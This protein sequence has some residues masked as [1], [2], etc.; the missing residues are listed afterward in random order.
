MTY[1]LEDESKGYRL[2]KGA[3]KF[4]LKVL[5]VAICAAMLVGAVKSHFRIGYDDSDGAAVRSGLKVRTDHKTGLQ[6]L[7]T[8]NGGLTPRLGRDGKQMVSE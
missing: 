5:I 1:S 4:C 3:G 7:E 6:Y 2:A 8:D